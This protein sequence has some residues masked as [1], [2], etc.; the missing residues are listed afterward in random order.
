MAPK[1]RVTCD[2]NGV[3]TF[4]PKKSQKFS[5][6][7][8]TLRFQ[9]AQHVAKLRCSNFWSKS[10]PSLKNLGRSSVFDL[11]QKLNDMLVMC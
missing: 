9:F 10:L 2:P 7:C 8:G 3:K 4:A 6:V 5:S 11:F 1:K